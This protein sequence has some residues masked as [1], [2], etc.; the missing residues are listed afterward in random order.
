MAAWCLCCRKDNMKAFHDTFEI[1]LLRLKRRMLTRPIRRG[2][3]RV[4]GLPHAVARSL[5]DIRFVEPDVIR[6]ILN[7]VKPGWVCVDVGAH[8]G[9]IAF[10]MAQKV[11]AAGRVHAVEPIPDNRTLLE[12]RLRVE[13]LTGRCE[14]HPI[15][16]GAGDC[17]VQMLR[18]DHST[19]WHFTSDAG[20]TSAEVR[21]VECRTFDAL[22]ASLPRIDL[23]KVDIEGAEVG[24]VAGATEVIAKVRPIWLFEMHG[25]AE[26]R[27]C[28]KFLE[29]S[30]RIFDI[31]GQEL[32][33]PDFET[34]GY[35]HIVA[36][37]GE[38]ADGLL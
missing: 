35:G 9:T 26:W 25:S 11:G 27:I 10:R 13:G 3:L 16:I 14:I 22:F 32:A 7:V 37:P 38:K 6:F 24:L 4:P 17:T 19:T 28:Q 36:C 1:S 31:S 23:V 29:N 12:A 30:Y 15:A 5:D 2:L 21:T 18:G 33:D 8:C 34:R 20:A